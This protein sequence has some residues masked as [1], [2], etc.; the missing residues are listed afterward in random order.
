VQDHAQPGIPRRRRDARS[1][2]PRSCDPEHGRVPY[3]P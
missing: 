1:H 3:G 2:R